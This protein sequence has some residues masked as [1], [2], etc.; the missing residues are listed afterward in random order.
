M[1]K[2][3]DSIKQKMSLLAK[4]INDVSY[5]LHLHLSTGTKGS[6]ELAPG[7]EWILRLKFLYLLIILYHKMLIFSTVSRALQ[8]WRNLRSHQSQY[9]KPL[10]SFCRNPWAAQPSFCYC[11]QSRGLSVMYNVCR[12]KL[13]KYF[14]QYN[15][16]II[17]CKVFLKMCWD[18]PWWC[19]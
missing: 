7:T 4:N 6:S 5:V 8:Y 11:Q 19:M 16:D 3:K 14:L 17:Q 10:V 18:R 13:T 15:Y 2:H 1:G 9:G 12:R